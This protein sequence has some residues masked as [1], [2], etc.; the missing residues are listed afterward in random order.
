MRL[1]WTASWLN[2]PMFFQIFP[3]P[4]SLY[5]NT[6]HQAPRRP[7]PSSIC[8]SE[9]THVPASVRTRPSLQSLTSSEDHTVV[10]SHADIASWYI[11]GY[12]Q[13][14]LD[15]QNE[16]KMAPGSKEVGGKSE[17]P[18]HYIPASRLEKNKKRRTCSDMLWGTIVSAGRGIA[19][20]FVRDSVE[21]VSVPADNL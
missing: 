21:P 19:S 8:I 20:I 16:K 5:M 9:N 17:L 13:A 3:D 11:L 1:T 6:S 14:G 2:T 12:P 18:M 15:Q 7:R 10:S 4:P